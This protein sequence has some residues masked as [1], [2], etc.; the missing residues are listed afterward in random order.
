MILLNYPPMVNNKRLQML[1]KASE[2]NC[3]AETQLPSTP[4]YPNNIG[5]FIID[6]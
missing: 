4:D 6:H 2:S 1:I 5:K 3:T